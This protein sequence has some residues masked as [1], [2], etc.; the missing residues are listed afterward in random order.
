MYFLLYNRFIVDLYFTE[1]D[2]IDSSQ[3]ATENEQII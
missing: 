1:T 3:V 2:V